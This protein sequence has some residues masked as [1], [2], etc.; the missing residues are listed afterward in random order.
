MVSLVSGSF[1]H[2]TGRYSKSLLEDL[3]SPTYDICFTRRPKCNLTLVQVKC[4]DFTSRRSCS[5][6]LL[7]MLELPP[8]L[9]PPRGTALPCWASAGER[10]P[11]PTSYVK[12]IC[13]TPRWFPPD[14]YLQRD[15]GSARLFTWKQLHGRLPSQRDCKRCRKLEHVNVCLHQQH[16]ATRTSWFPSLQQPASWHFLIGSGPKL[17]GGRR[18]FLCADGAVRGRLKRQVLLL[19]WYVPKVTS[20]RIVLW[21]FGLL[22]M[23]VTE[24]KTPVDLCSLKFTILL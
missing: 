5:M 18:W 3:L 24:K 6:W 7:E 22:Q 9:S 23:L 15:L 11:D 1:I 21:V 2:S 14:Y 8:M 16:E 12:Q 17:R 20:F 13:K 19:T 10:R 4:T